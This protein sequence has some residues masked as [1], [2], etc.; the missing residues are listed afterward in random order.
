MTDTQVQ[1][2]IAASR[3]RVYRALTQLDEIARW[4]FPS[5]M[6]SRIDR[7]DDSTFQ[8][9]LTYE[10]PGAEGKTTAHTDSYQGRFVHLRPPELVVEIDEFVTDNPSFQGAMTIT[11]ELA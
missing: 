4:R 3:E 9:S 6:S 7:S 5:D 10:Q 8:V 2:T 11:I 1:R